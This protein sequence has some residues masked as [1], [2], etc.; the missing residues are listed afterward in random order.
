[1]GSN[2]DPFQFFPFTQQE[3]SVCPNYFDFIYSTYSTADSAKY[4]DLPV[5]NCFSLT[6]INSYILIAHYCRYCQINRLIYHY[7]WC[8]CFYYSVININ[9]LPLFSSSGTFTLFGYRLVY[10]H[11][12]LDWLILKKHILMFGIIIKYQIIK[13]QRQNI[14]P[15]L[16]PSRSRVAYARPRQARP[17]LGEGAPG[18]RVRP[19]V[20]VCHHRRCGFRRGGLG[21]C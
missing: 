21:C 3:V 20:Y 15:L 7:C 6:Y 19:A 16:Q 17:P 14:A 1:M 13:R 12:K 9:Y 10:F 8:H 18:R 4:C 11:L 2:Y 5:L